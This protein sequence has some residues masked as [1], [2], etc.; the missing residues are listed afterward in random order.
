M[1][2][3]VASSTEVASA[4][5]TSADEATTA[6]RPAPQP[7]GP[8]FGHLGAAPAWP[9]SPLHVGFFVANLGLI[10]V[11]L[12]LCWLFFTGNT[13]FL[14]NYGLS[15][16]GGTAG[17][18]FGIIIL[19][20]LLISLVATAYL[21]LCEVLVQN[22]AHRK[23]LHHWD[24][25]KKDW[26][27]GKKLAPDSPEGQGLLN[28]LQALPSGT[29]LHRAVKSW[30]D[31]S[32]DSDAEMIV[33]GMADHCRQKLNLLQAVASTLVLVGLVGN[34]F[35]LSE[36][37]REMPNLMPAEVQG[38]KPSTTSYRAQANPS[39]RTETLVQEDPRPA[40]APA[41]AKVTVQT[42][43]D[44]LSVVVV[45]SVLGIGAMIVLL[46]DVAVFRCFFNALVADEVLLISA[47]IGAA[48]RPSTGS[49]Q[50]KLL[51]EINLK[52]SSLQ[53]IHA[54]VEALMNYEENFRILSQELALVL[55][56]QYEKEQTLFQELGRAVDAL[57]T[58]SL[59]KNEELGQYLN[60]AIAT[61]KNIQQMG[62]N[63]HKIGSS[64]AHLVDRYT[65]SAT[66][67]SAYAEAV[68]GL[69]EEDRAAGQ[70]RHEAMVEALASR[71]DQRARD[72]MQKTEA[73][74]ESASRE[75]E[76]MVAEI[77]RMRN[78]GHS[79]LQKALHDAQ[80]SYEEMGRR[81][82]DQLV[83]LNQQVR[84][85][86][87][88]QLQTFLA[89]AQTV[90]GGLHQTFRNELTQA[91]QQLRTELER[92]ARSVMAV[93][94]QASSQAANWEASLNEVAE[95]Q[96]ESSTRLVN[97]LEQRIA[98]IFDAFGQ[99]NSH[100]AGELAQIQETNRQAVQSLS[101]VLE[102]QVQSLLAEMQRL[103]EP[104][105]QQ[106]RENTREHS[107]G[108]R[109]IVQACDQLLEVFNTAVQAQQAQAS[110]YQEI[111]KSHLGSVR[112]FEAA[113]S[114][115]QQEWRAA[116]RELAQKAG[117]PTARPGGG[118]A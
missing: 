64:I 20:I 111:V 42:I 10:A 78:E 24:T 56:T 105:V 69:A 92:I 65:N 107:E 61:G 17:E 71:F 44:G 83:N 76:K 88:Q 117:L 29:R 90:H 40:A 4:G 41:T 82:Q 52:A 84:Q 7:K 100:R 38:A 96:R 47:E 39:G 81:S 32:P 80:Q 87:E 2:K 49:D 28:A 72:W 98:M 46:L 12:V 77:T 115:L 74:V 33:E 31:P 16:P 99:A 97:S 75:A 93:H 66:Q 104:S 59:A 55:K 22:P 18:F 45:S 35:G 6:A 43:A 26:P 116:V 86:A 110:N 51:A 14:K 36:A 30:T 68:R 73:I 60:N 118:S 19:F 53:A 67:L 50:L 114:G 27:A 109:R 63:L 5:A 21:F 95:Q 79:L 112:S 101:Q 25:L 1:E 102:G 62:E 57:N 113:V 48:L 58:Y 94:E 89:E 85:Q 11:N 103:M 54:R 106:L 23:A 15:D 9:Y 13:S 108:A 70:Q 3:H 8:N 34:F 91:H 37:V